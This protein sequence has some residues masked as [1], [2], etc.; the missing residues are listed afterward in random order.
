MKL[1]CIAVDDEPLALDLVVSYI[2]QTPFLELQSKY[3]NAI[4]ALTAIQNNPPDLIFLDIQMNGLN[5]IELAR[6]ISHLKNKVYII[7]TT[8][9]PQF[10]LEGYKVEAVDYLL[11]PFSYEDF[12]IA[13]QKVKSR[14][15]QSQPSM[16]Q[17]SVQENSNLFLKVE[18]QIIKI[19]FKE[20]RYIEGFKDYIKVHLVDGRVL[21]SLTSL[22]KLEESLPGTQF[23]RIHRSF[24]VAID[25]VTSITKSSV[26]I[27]KVE[28]SVSE[29]YKENFDKEFAGWRKE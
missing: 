13:A 11:K 16:S 24:I 21:L 10:A 29:A 6:V 20:I 12:L 5:G 15:E 25:K 9:Y 26:Y 8:A 4:D 28:I 23:I 22:K 19:P 17:P 1:T 2:H 27:D 3:D 7:F 18:H 14:F